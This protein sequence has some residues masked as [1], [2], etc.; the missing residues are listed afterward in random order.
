MLDG[1]ITIQYPHRPR[2]P[3]RGGDL[4]LAIA[5]EPP[6][7]ALAELA[8][9]RHR[10]VEVLARVDAVPADAL[11]P[12]AH[13]HEVV[14]LGP[15]RGV[16]VGA[17]PGVRVVLAVQGDGPGVG[18]VPADALVVPAGPLEAVPLARAHR[19]VVVARVGVVQAVDGGGGLRRRRP[20]G[21]L[22][23]PADP[24]QV[25]LL[26]GARRVEVLPA[27]GVVEPVHRL[28]AA[29]VRGQGG[30]HGE[31]QRPRAETRRDRQRRQPPAE[32]P[33][34]VPLPRRATRPGPFKVTIREPRSAGPRPPASGAP[35]PAKAG[36]SGRP[37]P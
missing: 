15:A 33:H 35:E 21:A 18:A 12:P 13:L 24:D 3:V 16:V 5:V 34:A 27:V 10:P 19:V 23:P 14:P 26:A 8:L 30:R 9:R 32:L 20:A 37:C 1:N 36:P 31:A 6:G 28:R 29:R 2:L 17:G 11:V 22:V 7:A 25:L 4:Q